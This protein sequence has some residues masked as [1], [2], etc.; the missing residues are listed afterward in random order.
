LKLPRL[1]AALITFGASALVP[2]APASAQEV[3]YIDCGSLRGAGSYGDPIQIGAITQVTV[4]YDCAPI[5]SGTGFNVRYFAFSLP[6][7]PSPDAVVMTSY[8]AGVGD[9]GVHPRLAWGPQTVKGSRGAA[10]IS[11]GNLE[12][13]YHVMTDLWAGDGWR[14]G[15]EKLRNPLGSTQTAWYHVTFVP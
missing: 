14:L 5:T 1:F 9:S 15:A 4:V 8:A 3:Q 12:G 13:F 7:G 6:Y 2:S 11:D 10:Y